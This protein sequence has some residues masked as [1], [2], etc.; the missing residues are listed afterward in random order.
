MCIFIPVPE[1]EW[2]ASLKKKG[3]G[4]DGR[5][6]HTYSK[7]DGSQRSETVEELASQSHDKLGDLGTAT[8]L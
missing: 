1:V 7:W 3:G 5:G 8:C 6:D 2:D 4:C